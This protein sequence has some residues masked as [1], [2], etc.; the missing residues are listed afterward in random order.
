M[1]LY[2][3]HTVQEAKHNPNPNP[4]MNYAKAAALMVVSVGLD[5][6]VPHRENPNPIPIFWATMVPVTSQND[7]IYGASKF[8]P[9]FLKNMY[10]KFHGKY[11][12]YLRLE[13]NKFGYSVHPMLCISV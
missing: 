5:L 7:V 11:V 4:V 2:G 13:L 8:A 6:G 12:H 9:Y 1:T 10:P 3:S